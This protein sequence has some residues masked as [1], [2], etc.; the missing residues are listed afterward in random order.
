MA[1]R[2]CLL[3]PNFQERAAEIPDLRLRKSWLPSGAA[4]LQTPLSSL[5]L[6]FR[7]HKGSTLDLVSLGFSHFTHPNILHVLTAFYSLR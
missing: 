1:I 3:C 6:T 4:A 5:G 7:T 2:S